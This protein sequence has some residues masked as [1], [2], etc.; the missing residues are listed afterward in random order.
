M[1]FYCTKECISG[2]FSNKF[3]RISKR[4]ISF[5]NC[6]EFR[7]KF[8]L[9][10]FSN[11]TKESE[12]YMFTR[13]FRVTKFVAGKRIGIYNG[14]QFQSFV[15]YKMLQGANLLN[16]SPTIRPPSINISKTFKK[17][18]SKKLFDCC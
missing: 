18:K 14:N 16:F 2:R 12:L 5:I 11:S 9:K 1:V 13:W 7:P 15:V 3:G 17:K 8:S 4:D 6:Y 10:K